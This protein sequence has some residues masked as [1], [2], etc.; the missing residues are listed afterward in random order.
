MKPLPLS[1]TSTPR[2]SFQLAVP[3][4]LQLSRFLPSN[5]VTHPALACA[6]ESPAYCASESTAPPTTSSAMPSV[7]QGFIVTSSRCGILIVPTFV[8]TFMQSYYIS[9][10]PFKLAP[11]RKVTLCPLSAVNGQFLEPSEPTSPPGDSVQKQV[12][13]PRLKRRLAAS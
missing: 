5:S 4:G 11:S 3:I 10:N 8:G 12:R 1:A 13:C 2:S 9:F 6:V 7:D